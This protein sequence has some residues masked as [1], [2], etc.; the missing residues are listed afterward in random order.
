[1]SAASTAL[2]PR[3][4]RSQLGA[5]LDADEPRLCAAP[6]R[7]ATSPP[8]PASGGSSRRP[9]RRSPATC[10]VYDS[11]GRPHD[12]TLSFLRTGAAN[13]WQVEI[14]GATRR[15]RPGSAPERPAGQRHVYLQWRRQPAAA[16]VDADVS[17]GTSPR[18]SGSQWAAAGG[19]DPAQSRSIS[20]GR[21]VDGLSQFASPTNV[22]Y[23]NQNGAEVGELN[24][25]EHRRRGLCDRLLHERREPPALPPADRHVRQSGAPRS[26]LGQCLCADRASGEFNLRDAGSTAAPAS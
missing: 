21:H 24:C 8:G 12:L 18:R 11:L 14:C 3:P 17:G 19:A 7:R 2:P 4:P 16:N 9:A 23:V 20:A 10:K 26:A 22:A 5:N 25:C 6:T 15:G 1:M 13:S